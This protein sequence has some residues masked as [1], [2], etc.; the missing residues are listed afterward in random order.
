MSGLPGRKYIIAAASAFAV[1]SAASGT[2]DTTI[3]G[4]L[5]S[6][7]NMTYRLEFFSVYLGP[8]GS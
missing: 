4:S 7:S 6:A 8:I 5:T 1:T 2:T 3:Q